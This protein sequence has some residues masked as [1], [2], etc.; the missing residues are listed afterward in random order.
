LVETNQRKR[1]STII[2][3]ETQQVCTRRIFEE[4]EKE[5]KFGVMQPSLLA[6]ITLQQDLH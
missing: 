1:D 3:K 6:Y 5:G 4:K 2:E